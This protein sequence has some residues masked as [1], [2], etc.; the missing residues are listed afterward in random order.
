M[1]LRYS[2]FVVPNLKVGVTEHFLTQPRQLW[3]V[4]IQPK[5]STQSFTNSPHRSVE[6]FKFDLR[7]N[8]SLQPA[9]D[10]NHVW[11]VR[12]VAF[13]RAG[14]FF[15]KHCEVREFTQQISSPTRFSG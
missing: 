15:L 5:T 4:Q 6:Y 14:K 13:A 9:I 12:I 3:M 8:S 7:A 10:L 11:I 1:V 2:V